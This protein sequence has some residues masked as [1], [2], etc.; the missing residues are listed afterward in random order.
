LTKT[1]NLASGPSRLTWWDWWDGDGA[2]TGSLTVNGSEVYSLTLDQN[3]WVFHSLDLTPW[4]NQTADISY[5]YDA[6][7]TSDGGAG[8]YLDDVVILG[9]SPEVVDFS[10]SSKSAPATVQSGDEFMYTI[11]IVNSSGVNAT[12]VSMIDPIPAGLTYVNGS[13]TGGAVYN[14][15]QNRIEWNGNVAASSSVVITFMVEATAESGMVTNTA[16]IDHSDISPVQVMATT[17][18]EEAEYL[19]YLPV[20]LK[21]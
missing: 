10:T 8:W 6:A 15:G 1:V 5:F 16:T 7:G 12:G 9:C 19:V 17:T 11:T 20:V 2:D 4:Q 3:E 14:A 21:R 18:I 13:V